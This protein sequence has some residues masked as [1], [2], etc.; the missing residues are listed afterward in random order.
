MRQHE[1]E[2]HHHHHYHDR[3]AQQQTTPFIDVA[4]GDHPWHCRP[5]EVISSF[6]S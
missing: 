1:G 3:H 5:G 4:A 2:A 6:A